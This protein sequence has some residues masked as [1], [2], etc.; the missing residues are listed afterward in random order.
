MPRLTATR[1]NTAALSAGV[2]V[3]FD[4]P[5]YEGAA[6]Q[7][8]GYTD[9]YVDARNHGIRALLRRHRATDAADLPN[10]EVRALT[11]ECLI[12]HTLVDVRGFTNDDDT[13][14]TIAQF[15]DTL[16]DQPANLAL[17]VAVVGAT[18]RAGEIRTAEVEEAAGN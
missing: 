4:E 9:A 7:T 6:I 3:E 14:T 1:R 8:R 17:Y 15:R 16:R 11:I 12:T 2:W 18:A 5:E 10:A 13:P